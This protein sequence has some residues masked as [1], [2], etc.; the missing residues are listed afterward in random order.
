MP[1]VEDARRPS[2]TADR[3]AARPA[4]RRRQRASCRPHARRS[5]RA[6]VAL[7]KPW[8]EN[9]DEGWTRWL[10]EQLRVPVHERHRRR[11]PRRQ[12]ARAVRRH[13]PAERVGR[14]LL[15]RHWPPT[16]AARVRRRPRRGRRRRAAGVRAGRRHAH[17]PRPVRRR[18]PSRR[19]TCRSA[20]SPGDAGDRVLLPRI[21]PPARRRSGQPL[22]YGMR[23]QTAGFFSFSSAYEA[24]P[25]AAGVSDA[26]SATPTRTCSSA[27]GSRASR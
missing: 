13:H 5:A 16:S 18:S 15:S 1:A 12:P 9:I 19:S 2:L 23:P 10:L 17:L 7:Y 20:T 3:D 11:H 25:D 6:R 22:S 4:R 21:D 14:R 24:T 8:I 27:A 26:R